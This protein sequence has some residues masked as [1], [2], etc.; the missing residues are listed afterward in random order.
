MSEPSKENKPML[1][2]G[3]AENVTFCAT[4]VYF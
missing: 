3:F 1:W 2:G 4:I